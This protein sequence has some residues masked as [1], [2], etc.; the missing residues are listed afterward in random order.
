MMHVVMSRQLSRPCYIEM[1]QTQL[2]ADLVSKVPEYMH[3]IYE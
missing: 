1:L 2:F 3:R